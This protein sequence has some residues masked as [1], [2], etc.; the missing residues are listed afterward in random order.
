MQFVQDRRLRYGHLQEVKPQEG[1]TSCECGECPSN[2]HTSSTNE[3]VFCT[4]VHARPRERSTSSHSLEL[5]R[6]F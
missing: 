4:S 3:G 5:S 1:E 2:H 6:T